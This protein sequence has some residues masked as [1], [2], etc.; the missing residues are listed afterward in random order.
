M[1]T[2]ANSNVGWALVI[3]NTTVLVARYSVP[4]SH[5]NEIS[6]RSGHCCLTHKLEHLTTTSLQP[7]YSAI[8]RFRAMRT[9]LETILSQVTKHSISYHHKANR[10]HNLHPRLNRLIV[11]HASVL[12]K[13]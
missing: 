11:L 7:V 2:T 1:Y 3:T 9:H 13:I 12:V 4:K 8:Y 10:N 6:Q 5:R